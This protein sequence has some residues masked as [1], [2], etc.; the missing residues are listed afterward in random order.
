MYVSQKRNNLAAATAVASAE[1]QQQKKQQKNRGDNFITEAYHVILALAWN[2][3]STGKSCSADVQ[4]KKMVIATVRWL[5]TV[6]STPKYSFIKFHKSVT[7]DNLKKFIS[8]DNG[9]NMTKNARKSVSVINNQIT[10]Q[11]KLDPTPGY[12][13]GR[14]V[15]DALE[16]VKKIL[17]KEKEEK[18][19]KNKAIKSQ[20]YTMKEYDANADIKNPFYFTFLDLG[21][22]GV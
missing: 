18:T 6:F 20:L 14:P 5:D 3:V 8:G 21:K 12:G 4:A 9:L 16:D 13:S 1:P 19:K 15:E 22:P 17:H 11:Y 7:V 2:E 10:P